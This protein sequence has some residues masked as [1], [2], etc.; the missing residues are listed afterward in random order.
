MEPDKSVLMEVIVSTIARRGDGK[1]TP[2]RIVRQVFTK[3]GHLIAEYDPCKD[4]QFK[5]T[6]N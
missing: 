6:T 5:V 2:I 3:E 4:D 1:D